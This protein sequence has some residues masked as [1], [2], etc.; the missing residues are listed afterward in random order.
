MNKVTHFCPHLFV[1][2]YLA[3]R[4]NVFNQKKSITAFYVFLHYFIQR[5]KE[6]PRPF[7]NAI[8]KIRL[9]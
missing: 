5:R 3:K 2:F 6:D 8:E 9:I 7:F 1:C 4:C